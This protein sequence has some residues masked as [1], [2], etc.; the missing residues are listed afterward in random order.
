MAEQS[1]DQ[2]RL[3]EYQNR[4]EELMATARQGIGRQ[5]PE[6]L[7]K[8]A[9]T[10]INIGRRLEDMA[11]DARER[12]RGKGEQPRNPPAGSSDPP[13]GLPCLERIR[14]RG[15]LGHQRR[16][17]SASRA[18][19][20]TGLFGDEVIARTSPDGRPARRAAMNGLL[21][22]QGSRPQTPPTR[23]EPNLIGRILAASPVSRSSTVLVASNWASRHDDSRRG[24]HRLQDRSPTSRRGSTRLP[25]VPRLVPRA[26]DDPV[27]DPRCC[28]S[29][30]RSGLSGMGRLDSTST[31]RPPAEVE[32]S[33]Y[34]RTPSVQ[35]V[36]PSRPRSSLNT[37]DAAVGTKA[38]HD[39]RR[40]RM[41]PRLAPAPPC[42][43]R[44][45]RSPDRYPSVCYWPLLPC[46]N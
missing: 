4:L 41:G 3:Q 18:L 14:Y 2:S 17:S 1:T 26:G 37:S 43:P 39:R 46:W 27:S 23:R 9:A 5:T 22:P 38:V 12:D 20:A 8:A 25:L 34:L 7:D 45:G 42:E 21:R 35:R 6:V 28:R 31:A 29:P 19:E 40:F 44:L 36:H 30:S 32:R 24:G 16:A 11:S 15:R 13:S 33:P 10:A